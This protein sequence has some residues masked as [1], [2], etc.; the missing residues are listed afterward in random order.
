MS[1]VPFP[2]GIVPW[3]ALA[4]LLTLPTPLAPRSP[5]LLAS[6]ERLDRRD[7]IDEDMCDRL[8]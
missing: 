6:L 4:G 1:C 5:G 8:L 2:G 7:L 3:D